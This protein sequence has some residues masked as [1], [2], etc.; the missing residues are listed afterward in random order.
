MRNIRGTDAACLAWHPAQPLLAVAW[1]DGAL[2]LWDADRQQLSEDSKG[3]RQAVV[4]L[5]WHAGG[6]HLL[7]ADAGGKVCARSVTRCWCL[8]GVVVDACVRAD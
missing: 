5:A 3:H 1:Q 8:H 4:Q 2:S 7:S 6:G